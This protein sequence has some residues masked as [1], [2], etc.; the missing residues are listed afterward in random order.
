MTPFEEAQAEL[1][2]E[3]H[4]FHVG[5]QMA[6]KESTK[7]FYLLYVKSLALSFMKQCARDEKTSTEDFVA[8]YKSVLRI[9]KAPE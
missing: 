2:A 5:T 9:A 1:T 4:E 3:V 8:R 6:P 7:D